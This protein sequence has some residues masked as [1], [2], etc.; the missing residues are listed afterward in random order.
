[1]EYDAAGSDVVVRLTQWDRAP[2]SPM[3]EAR[4]AHATW[5]GYD[6]DARTQ[7]TRTTFHGHEAALA[8]TT[9]GMDDSPTRV[10]QLMIRTADGRLYELRVD[11]P[12]GTPEEKKGT[13]LFKGVRDRLVLGTG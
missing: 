4:Q 9:Y 2:R 8:D 7:Y 13:A 10:L 3:A 6:G 12:K 11:M 1:V 5:D